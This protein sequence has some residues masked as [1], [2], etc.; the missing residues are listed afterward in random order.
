MP[1]PSWVSAVAVAPVPV[2]RTQAAT[3]KLRLVSTTGP[4]VCAYELA[5]RRAAPFLPEVHVAPCSVTGWEPAA[6]AAR[7]P[8]PS[9]SFQWAAGSAPGL[10]LKM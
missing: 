8:W 2:R 4:W 5:R 6:S 1:V 10:T 3:A 9:S 7:V